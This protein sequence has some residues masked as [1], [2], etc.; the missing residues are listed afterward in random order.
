MRGVLTVSQIALALVLLTGAG[1][2]MRSFSALRA[3]D[4]GFDP[5][6]TL[7]FVVSTTGSA[8]AAPERRVALF[9]QVLERVRAM[10]GVAS[11]SAINHLPLAGD[12]WGIT[13]TVP[14]AG[15]ARTDD[16]PGATYRV[17]QPGYF[18]TMGIPLVRGRDVRDGDRIGGEEVVV[19]NE[20]MAGRYWPAQDPVGQRIEFSEPGA[21]RRLATVVGVV[22]NVVRS[23]W[24][25]PPS[26]EVYRPF[27]Q[28]RAYVESDGGHVA[29]LTFVVRP[30][31]APDAS[32]CDPAALAA[33]I[34]AALREL[35]PDAPVSDVQT[36]E[37]VVD[38]AN[39]RPRFNV[40]LLTLF[41]GVALA[42]AAVGIYGVMSY[43]VSR[44][45]HEIGLRMALG[46]RRGDVLRLVVGR[47]MTLS[48]VGT[49]VGV[50]GALALSRFMAG[51]LFGVRPADLPTLAAMSALLGAV[52][53]VACLVPAWRA[54]AVSP[55][56]ALRA[57][58]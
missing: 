37:Q 45:T 57:S 5:T 18:A 49:A 27:R 13:Y 53:L 47:G 34:R 35:A 32:A 20:W 58:E 39:A 23:E 24:G 16:P 9:D 29:S 41:A 46:A 50:A 28:A 3:L 33:P 11:A 36:I 4:P 42:L 12:M 6:A 25:A 19:V 22:R 55:M 31:C 21:E 54:V 38:A 17:V 48:L 44:R 15:E 43:M 7:S 40:V 10:P 56:R 52:A 1:L 2:L 51:M 26:A 30:S 14:G 8:H